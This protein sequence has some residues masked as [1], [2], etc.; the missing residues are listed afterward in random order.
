MLRRL[1][2]PACFFA[3][4]VT[5]DPASPQTPITTPPDSQLAVPCMGCILTG[6][7]IQ[8]PRVDPAWG[9]A[10]LGFSAT[11]GDSLFGTINRES[12]ARGV[13]EVMK[14]CRAEYQSCKLLGCDR[15]IRSF[16][17]IDE[18]WTNHVSLRKPQQPK[19]I[20][21]PIPCFSFASH[22]ACV[23]KQCN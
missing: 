10:A 12:Q 23:R 19:C 3:F 5:I 8:P 13:A 1:I 15:N 9:C 7:Q 4:A 22:E 11:K 2:I 21:I 18:H 20:E 6:T 14:S 17:Q 16:K